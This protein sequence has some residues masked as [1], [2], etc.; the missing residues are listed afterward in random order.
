MQKCCKHTNHLDDLCTC[1][2]FWLA[3]G[4]NLYEL[5]EVAYEVCMFDM[6]CICCVVL[7]IDSFVKLIARTSFCDYP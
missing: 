6:F 4:F 1:I 3:Y 2:C 5:F 7:I